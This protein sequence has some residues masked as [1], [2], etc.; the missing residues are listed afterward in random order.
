M[1]TYVTPSRFGNAIRFE[2]LEPRQ[3]RAG[4]PTPDGDVQMLLN[5]D[6]G[7]VTQVTAEQNRQVSLP[8]FT[9]FDGTPGFHLQQTDNNFEQ[10]RVDGYYMWPNT[11]GLGSFPGANANEA[12]VRQLAREVADSGHDLIV[13]DNETWHFDIRGYSRAV[14][15]KTIADMKQVI[16]WVRSERPQ[17]KVGIYGYMSQS[18]DNS[19]FVWKLGSDTAAA[20]DVWYQNN[21]QNFAQR[22][23]PW[24]ATSEYLRPL[25]DSVDYMFPVLYTGTTDMDQWDRTAKSTIEDSRRYG[26]PVIPFLMPY[27]HEGAGGSLAG[28]ELPT[29]YWQRQLDLVRQYADGAVIWT[30]QTAANNQA[31][32]STLL[33]TVD[34]QARAAAATPHAAPSWYDMTSSPSANRPAVFADLPID[35][36]KDDELVVNA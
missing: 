26:K 14:V 4:D 13:F 30:S 23:A 8:N 11:P 7:V 12:G 32:V 2:Q 35:G 16:S 15:D 21:M 31:W 34:P 36:T 6:G 24:Q 19:S 29:E 20:G 33:S 1:R 17:L 5:P 25:A 28:T 22:F 3:L 9:W 10:A 27:Y 18:D